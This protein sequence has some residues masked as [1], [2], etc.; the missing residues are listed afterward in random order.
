MRAKNVVKNAPLDMILT[1]R[2]IAAHTASVCLPP[3]SSFDKR[4]QITEPRDVSGVTRH[5]TFLPSN[6]LLT[7]FNWAFSILSS[8]TLFCVDHVV[9]VQCL[10]LTLIHHLLKGLQDSDNCRV[11]GE[12]NSH[13]TLIIRGGR[14]KQY[15][16]L[17]RK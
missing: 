9:T 15:L 7:L 8:Q 4:I 14:S 12:L 10:S 16:Y 17:P 5:D 1:L 13:A 11:W 3:S 6:Y 2:T